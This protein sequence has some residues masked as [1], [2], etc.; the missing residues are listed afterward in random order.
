MTQA[1]LWEGKKNLG[2]SCVNR[3][4]S[5]KPNAGK[6]DQSLRPSPTPPVLFHVNKFVLVSDAFSSDSGGDYWEAARH[7]PSEQQVALAANSTRHGTTG[8]VPWHQT[9]V[10]SYRGGWFHL[11]YTN[12]RA[13][14]TTTSQTST[15]TR[16][17][18]SRINYRRGRQRLMT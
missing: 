11:Y 12:T 1:R 3:S 4:D 10:Y 15:Y 5:L 7:A 13:S 16:S 6:E 8:W 17:G 9:C 14:G 18:E 2:E